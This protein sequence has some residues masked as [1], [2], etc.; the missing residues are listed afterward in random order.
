MEIIEVKGLGD[1]NTMSQFREV[2][3][4]VYRA[5]KVWVPESEKLLLEW[6]SASGICDLSRV[7][8]VIG[9]ENNSPVARGVAILDTGAEPQGWIGF[10]ESLEEYQNV[11]LDVVRRCEEVLQAAGATSVL[12]PKF[13][14][15]LVGFQTDGFE[16]PQT[17]LTNHNP[18]YYLPIFQRS[19][20]QVHSRMRTIC[21]DRETVAHFHTR[22]KG[23]TTRELNPERL[24]QELAIFNR[25]QGSIFASRDGYAPRTLVE[26]QK[27]LATFLPFLDHNLVIIAEDTESNSV[28]VL[29]CFPDVYQ[30][31]KGQKIDRARIMSIGVAP[32]WKRNGVGAMMASHLLRNLL[33]KGYRTAEAA[34]ILERNSP[35]QNLAKRFNGEVGRKFV[36]LKKDL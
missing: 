24:S 19:G 8:T 31:F 18:A 20:Y 23:F 2:A 13:N 34:W 22:I 14:N 5:D 33:E 26:D 25:L 16:L 15:L 4:R 32:G 21:F 35:P 17:F 27:M 28:G 9:R 29:I 7:W 30:A 12:A 10:F 11:A 36:L 1:Q 3:L 6:L